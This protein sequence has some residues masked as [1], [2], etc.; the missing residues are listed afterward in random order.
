MGSFPSNA[1]AGEEKDIVAP[2]AETTDELPSARTTVGVGLLIFVRSF[3]GELT[4]IEM[5]IDAT[6]RDLLRAYEQWAETTGGH[7][8]YHEQRLCPHD[9][10]ADCSLCQ[11]SVVEYHPRI[12]GWKPRDNFVLRFAVENLAKANWEM[13]VDVEDYLYRNQLGTG[14]PESYHIKDWDVSHIT[15]MAGLFCPSN[16][17]ANFNENISQWDTS[18]VKDMSYMFSN[19]KKFNQDIGDWNTSKVTNMTAMFNG[20]MY[21]NQDIGGWDTGAVTIM[22]SMFQGAASFNQDIGM[23]D[24]K[25]VESMNCMFSNATMFNQ[26]L[27]KWNTKAVKDMTWMF[28]NAVLFNQD[29][30]KW[31]LSGKSKDVTDMFQGAMSYNQVSIFTCSRFRICD[32]H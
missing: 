32:Y 17:A 22:S 29:V 15:S 23:W 14:E 19:C 26:N 11:E 24:T 20:A 2:A 27:N 10:L 3:N 25:C 12:K 16:V 4:P 13:N 7:L 31:D 1:R 9:A 5:N 6:V 18:A 30:G 8:K 28:K 21:F